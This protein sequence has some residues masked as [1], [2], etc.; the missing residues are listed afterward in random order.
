MVTAKIRVSMAGGDS[1]DVEIENG[2]SVA[3]IFEALADLGFTLGA[4]VS[5]NGETV[6]EDAL[7]EDGDALTSHRS[8]EGN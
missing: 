1:V 3:E 6:D 4:K 2:V 8:P 5:I 7:P